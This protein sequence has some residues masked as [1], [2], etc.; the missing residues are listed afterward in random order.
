MVVVKETSLVTVMGGIVMNVVT[1]TIWVI[2][3]GG[4][5]GSRTVTVHVSVTVHISFS[6]TVSNSPPPP[7]SHNRATPTINAPNKNDF[8][9]RECHRNSQW[10]INTP[11]PVL[12]T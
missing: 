5:A 2:V 12:Q 8:I 10:I 4:G 7:P 1:E 3:T 6:V 11:V 9:G